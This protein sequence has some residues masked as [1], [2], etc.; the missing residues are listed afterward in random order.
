M[1][2]VAQ[3]DEQQVYFG[4]HLCPGPNVIEKRLKGP[5]TAPDLFHREV[6]RAAVGERLDADAEQQV[7]AIRVDLFG[8]LR[9]WNI[10]RFRT[11]LQRLRKVPHLPC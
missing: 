11:S 5:Q 8:F 4:Q 7:E 6:G 2:H 1:Q 3:L 9:E 10:T